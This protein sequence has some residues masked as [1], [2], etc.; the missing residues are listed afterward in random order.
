MKSKFLNTIIF[1]FSAFLSVSLLA[2]E[3]RRPPSIEDYAK[4]FSKF[5]HTASVKEK[6][7]AEKLRLKTIKAISKIL[8]SRASLGEREFELYLR[9]GEIMTERHDYYRDLEY[10]RYQLQYKSWVKGK[11]KGPEPQLSHND[12]R[13][14]LTSAVNVFRK[15]VSKFPK[16]PRTDGALFALGTTLARLGN[17]NADLYFNQ[18]L[19]THPRSPLVPDT[20]LALGEH[21]FENQNVQKSIQNYRG[22]LKF[23]K[24]KAYPYAVYKLGWSHYNQAFNDE[25]V[26]Q[27]HLTK[28]AAA[29]KLVVKLA[30]STSRDTQ[31]S[32]KDEAL[33][34][35]V[36]V[37][38][39]AEDIQSAWDYFK[40][41]D[42]ENKFYAMLERLGY[43]YE[44][45]GE[46]EK[47][48]RV[49]A[50]LLREAPSRESNYEVSLTVVSLYEGL[51]KP[52][53]VV[54]SLKSYSK[55]YL[56]KSEWVQDLKEKNADAVISAK[57][58]FQKELQR[59][60]TSFHQYGAENDKKS[61]VAA[62]AS[63][64]HLYLKHFESSQTSVEMRFYLATILEDFKKYELA[65]DQYA[66]VAEPNTKFRPDAALSAISTLNLAIL[67]QEKSK[68]PP[69]GKAAKKIDI[70]REQ[71]K[72]IKAIHAYHKFY[73][74]DK[75]LA[76]LKSTIAEIYFT[77]GHYER[78]F[79]VY[80]KIM[81]QH[82]ATQQ[83]NEA[84]KTMISYHADR[85]QWEDVIKVSNHI[86]SHDGALADN[87]L[88]SWV[89]GLVQ[90]SMFKIG[91]NYEKNKSYKDAS[92]TFMSLYQK[93]PKA[94]DA[95]LALYKASLN[96]HQIGEVEKSLDAN[97]ILIDK[98]PSS[99]LKK[100]VNAIVAQT[101]ESLAQFDLAA[102]Y[103]KTL[104]EKYP[105]DSRSPG[106]L[107]NATVLYRGL[108]KYAL[109]I[110]SAVALMNLHPQSP[111][112]EKVAFETSEILEAAGKKDEARRSYAGFQRRFPRSERSLVAA[113]RSAHLESQ[114]N[115]SKGQQSLFRVR[116]Q[117]LSTQ[118]APIEA[119]NLVAEGMFRVVNAKYKRFLD[120]PLGSSQIEKSI[121]N[122][123]KMLIS[124]VKDY[125]VVIETGSGE[126]TVASLYRMGRVHEKLA[127]D[128]FNVEAPSGAGEDVVNAFKSSLEQVAFP[129]K[130]EAYKYYE[131]AYNSSR[132]VGTFSNW[133]KLAYEKMAELRPADHKKINAETVNPSYFSHVLKVSDSRSN[134]VQ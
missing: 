71:K 40:N 68:L 104:G 55:T 12:S 91:E 42:E 8:K 18:L 83:N 19:K 107:Y 134:L 53:K 30:S 75:S 67:Q 125:E 127:E 86:A 50:R 16:H 56:G 113:A 103:Y 76:K 25:S 126:F 3:E 79:D 58:D 93:F 101:Y 124:L 61:Y 46:Q 132:D 77:H 4:Y 28:A 63:L 118:N 51:N 35:L 44:E 31:Y 14:L 108:K 73:P 5:D 87:G 90:G 102:K 60:A 112:Y 57:E 70:P 27:K 41:L 7:Q 120:Y 81:K 89:A 66:K 32:L 100:D 36:M 98:F 39:D 82:P 123:N 97:R 99:P 17:S 34:D 49:F 94:K 13:S 95:D 6:K 74:Q 106:A 116:Q 92:S 69:R 59:Y 119:R 26:K 115:P 131:H 48:I 9:L 109:A 110:E 80:L 64:Y 37:W 78:S 129:L 33:N 43:L 38:A 21:Y 85:K 2:R 22:V 122:K 1:L 62:A 15:L 20:F 133:T 52:K 54:S 105:K 24:H 114:L 111:L 11:K 128:L 88:R 29:F 130:E 65:S 45:N 84:V 121:Q 47:S 23:P 72:L 10:S 96:F 117:L